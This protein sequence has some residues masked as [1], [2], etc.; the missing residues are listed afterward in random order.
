MF[1][2]HTF[3]FSILSVLTVSVNGL[4]NSCS[5]PLK[6]GTAAPSDPY[7]M[8]TI[9]H[10]G[11]SAFNNDTSYEVF[12]N[13][14][15]YGAVG[16]G[17]TDDTDA[18]NAAMSTGNRCGG[19]TCETST[20]T[21][22]I[23]YFPSGTY[24][25]S[26]PI[27]TYYYTQ[28]IGDAKRPPTLLAS[29]NFTGLAVIDANPY[30]PNGGGSQWFINDDNIF[31]SVRN[32]IIDLRQMPASAPAIGLHWEVSKA[33]SLMNVIVEMSTDAGTQ[34][35]GLFM[36]SGSGGFMG[37]KFGIAVGNR[38]FMV[39]NLTVNN[40]VVAVS[41][42]W[43]W[44]WTFQGVTIKNCQIGFNLTTGSTTS[45]IQTVGA[46]AIVDAVVT[47][48]PVFISS[49]VASN[50]TLAGS[51]V[52]NNILLKNVPVAVGTADGDVVLPGG[53]EV[54]IESWGQGNVYSGTS[55]TP[56]FTQGPI[57]AVD[58][59]RNIVDSAGRVFG[60]TYPQYANYAVDQIISVKAEGAAGDGVTD[61]TDA[62][63]KV[64]EKY[65][66]CKLIFFDA[67][68]YYVTDTIFIPADTQVIGEA[69]STILGGGDRFQNQDEPHVMVK[70]GEAYTQGVLEITG[71]M[72]STVGPAP[73]AIVL[74]WNV[75]E[76]WNQQGGAGMWDTIGTNL[77]IS[78]CPAG[79]LSPECQAAFLGLHLTPG[80]SAYLEGMWVWTADH[81]LDDPSYRQTSI[82]TGRGILSES[83]GPIWMLILRVA[84]HA[85]LYQYHLNN[86]QNHWFGLAQAEMPYYQPIPNAP[87]PYSSNPTYHD[88]EFG[89]GIDN[90]WALYVQ[91]SQSIVVYGAGFYS[92][93]QNYTQDCQADKTCQNQIVNVDW[94]STV[95]VYSLSTAGTTYQLSVNEVGVIH[96]SDNPDGSQETATAWFR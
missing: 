59:P 16:D 37:G 80:S 24:L 19:A 14:K 62:I 65:A 38:Q 95:Q 2:P 66:G 8:E 67:G 72:F 11:K 57:Q 56:T 79:T 45:A 85:A 40:A 12:R 58:K 32:M 41:S 73:G 23:V 75:R 61:D 64:F 63:R 96:E 77:G 54:P 74:E 92:F 35:Q 83:L 10:R 50:G 27:D 90:A 21:P 26:S 5:A 53:D 46:E 9:P 76:P 3:F 34:H 15:D 88:P 29:A 18:I 87:A 89:N 52:L 94:D 6:W 28:L 39:R 20:L 17:V 47:D 22:G 68:T 48:T 49:S 51:L 71:M 78:Q 13:V 70:I 91:N 7:W 33:T 30:V 69:W 81:D 1:S 36:E 31:R 42:T 43:N 84:E 60:K 55:G 82:F 93:F 4:G 44:D 86:A 25:V